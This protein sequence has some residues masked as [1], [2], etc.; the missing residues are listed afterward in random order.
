MG[1]LSTLGKIFKTTNAGQSWVNITGNLPNVS[2]W[3]LVPHPSN[4]NVIA[5]GSELGCFRTTDGGTSWHRWNNGM[6]DYAWAT[7]LA[8]I[9]Q[10]ATTGEVFVVAGTFGRSAW[11]REISGG[12]AVAAKVP[13]PPRAVDLAP[14]QPN[15]F[16]DRTMIEFSLPSPG[17]ARLRVFD[18][19]G[20]LIATLLDRALPAGVHRLTFDGRHVPP[21]VYWCRLEAMGAVRSRTMVVSR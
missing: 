6:P 8:L 1:G 16:G 20:R 12:D 17:A 2:F 3:S 4:D 15:P 11:K 5:V 9:D 10:R 13:G 7:E 21:G 19:A 18:A 14:N